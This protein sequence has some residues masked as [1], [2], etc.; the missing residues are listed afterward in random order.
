VCGCALCARV[1]RHDSNPTGLCKYMYVYMYM[2]IYTYIY[3]YIYIYIQ[4]PIQNVCSIDIYMYIQSLVAYS[5]CLF[6][7]HF[8]S[9]NYSESHQA[10]M[11][12]SL[13]YSHYIYINLVASRLFRIFVLQSCYIYINYPESQRQTLVKVCCIVIVYTSI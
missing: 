3:I 8:I 9:I 10:N 6:H 1:R 11:G 12:Q 2:Y 5:E 7:S 13:L 4:S